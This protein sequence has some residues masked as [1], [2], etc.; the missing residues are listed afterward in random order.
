LIF[1][2]N[3]TGFMVGS[4]YEQEGIIKNGAKLI[5]AVSN[6][7]VPAL[8]VMTGASY[9]A[10][11]YAM[12]GRSYAPRF[13]FTWPQHR[14]AVMGGEQLGGVLEIIQRE[15]AARKGI[16]IDEEGLGMM[17]QMFQMQIEKESTAF[18]ATARLWDDGIID[19]RDTRDVL[20]I[21]L[22][23]IANEEVKGTTSFGVF[24]H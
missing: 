19:P 13:L 20:G 7:T 22:S 14:I 4:Q 18:Y 2:Q 3:I 24:R 21:S 17:R 9:G 12:C 16:E 8:T 5:N 11:N 6:S 15:A 10:G 1:L 23:A